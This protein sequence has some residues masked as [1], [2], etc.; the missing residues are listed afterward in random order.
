LAVHAGA[1]PVAADRLAVVFHVDAV[2]FAEAVED[3]AG[4]PDLVGGLLGA[5][6]EDLEFPLALGHLGVDAFVVDAGVEAEVEVFLDDLAGDVADVP[7]SRRRSSIR[8]A[9]PG[10]PS[11]GETERAAVLGEEI[12]L[13]EAEPGAR[14]VED[15]G[16]G[17]GRVRGDAVGH[18]DLAHHQ[19]AVDAG[20][21]RVAP[22]PA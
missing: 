12:F 20:A 9:G 2:F 17:V 16:A 18:H 19:H 15:G 6:A 4:H 22:R 7:C 3:V 10:K 21:V 13:L 14:I 11:L 1:V 5:L 8:P